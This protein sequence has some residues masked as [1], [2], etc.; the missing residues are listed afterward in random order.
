MCAIDSHQGV[1]QP[2]QVERRS[3]VR[4]GVAPGNVGAVR[5]FHRADGRLGS[6]HSDT[7]CTGHTGRCC[8]RRRRRVCDGEFKFV[9]ALRCALSKDEADGG[10]V[11]GENAVAKPSLHVE[12]DVAACSH[13]KRPS[14]HQIRQTSAVV[15][16]FDT[17]TL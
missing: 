4:G 2:L 3:V 1:R 6:Q 7:E 11:L 15:Y 9:Q 12:C 8:L 14:V 13:P 10:E 16:N 17:C 5:L